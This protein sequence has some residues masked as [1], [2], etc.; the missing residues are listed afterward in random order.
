MHDHLQTLT[1]EE[2]AARS[3]AMLKE[4]LKDEQPGAPPP[5]FATVP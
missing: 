2:R 5:G 3:E 4:M 1:D